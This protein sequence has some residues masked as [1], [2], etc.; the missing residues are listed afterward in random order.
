MFP[1]DLFMAATYYALIFYRIVELNSISACHKSTPNAHST[2]TLL[3]LKR[4]T[5]V[6]EIHA[7]NSNSPNGQPLKQKRRKMAILRTLKGHSL[8]VDAEAGL[9][10]RRAAVTRKVNT[11]RKGSAPRMLASFRA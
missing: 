5:S 9:S 7:T 8:S 1:M 2:S 3:H 6:A 10:T 11:E 4:A